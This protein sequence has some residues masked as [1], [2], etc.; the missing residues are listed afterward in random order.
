MTACGLL[1]VTRHHRRIPD[2]RAEL[3]TGNP[4][5]LNGAKLRGCGRAGNARS[6]SRAELLAVGFNRPCARSTM[7]I[8]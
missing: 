2:P 3:R 7:H 8:P 4:L 5:I 6:P 1:I